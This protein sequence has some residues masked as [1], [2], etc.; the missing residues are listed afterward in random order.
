MLGALHVSSACI[1]LFS[2]NCMFIHVCRETG[3]V[4]MPIRFGCR[5][6]GW[7]GRDVLVPEFVGWVSCCGVALIA[8]LNPKP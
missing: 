7:L 3:Q 1:Y 4:H 6:F 5:G 8:T 2:F